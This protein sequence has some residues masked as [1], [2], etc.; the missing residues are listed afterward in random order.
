[1]IIKN[2]ILFV[3]VIMTLTVMTSYPVPALAT[4]N[5]WNENENDQ[6]II[7]KGEDGEQIVISLHEGPSVRIVSDKGDEDVVEIDLSGISEIVSEAMVVI[8]ESLAELSEMQIE[9]KLGRE[10]VFVFSDEDDEVMV[11]LEEVFEN[12]GGLLREAFEDI[13]FEIADSIDKAWGTD[14]LA[15]EWQYTKDDDVSQAELLQL[16]LDQL[17]VEL[18]K[19]REDLRKLK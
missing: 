19:L 10:N 1:M 15:D 17:R 5:A 16:E 14:D 13:D 2:I 8:G 12:V 4:T 9:M 3:L 11:N 6:R 7:V 18:E